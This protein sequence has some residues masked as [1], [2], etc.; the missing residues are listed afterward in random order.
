MAARSLLTFAH[1]CAGGDIMS[2]KVKT[3]AI[4]FVRRYVFW[5]SVGVSIFY[6]ETPDDICA[7]VYRAA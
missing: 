4:T 6:I 7:Q 2:K 5:K 1:W 3:V